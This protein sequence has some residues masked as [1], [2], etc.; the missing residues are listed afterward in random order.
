MWFFST[1]LRRWIF[2]TLALPLLGKAAHRL[3]QEVER[4][5]GPSRLSKGLHQAGNLTGRRA[6]APQR[7]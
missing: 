6:R 1:R 5:N 3:G 7:A 2:T 4:K